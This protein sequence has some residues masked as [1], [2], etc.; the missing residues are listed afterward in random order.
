[1]LPPAES[2]PAH[3]QATAALQA[4]EARGFAGSVVVACDDDVVFQG[5]FG[6]PDRAGR[7]PSYWV[8]SISKQFAA[9]AILKLREEGRLSLDDTVERFFP[10]APRD[11]A[12]ITIS[13][14]L[15]HFSGLP[16]Q[17]YAADGVA[18]RNEAARAILSTTLA[19]EPG[20]T[21]A[22]SNDNYSLVAMIVE[23]ASGRPFEEFVGDELFAPAHLDDAGFWPTT[24]NDY[25]PP[26]LHLP[27]GAMAGAHWG[28]RGAD[29]MR[30]SVGDLHRWVR[31]LDSG[32]ALL[33]ESVRL[34]YGPN[35]RAGDGDGVGFGWF[36]SDQP[37]GRWLWTRGTEDFGGNAIVYR[38]WGTPLTIIAATNA[39]PE[40]SA[41]P[42]WSRQARDALMEIYNSA[43]CTR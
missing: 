16:R 35:A 33:P 43:A 2:Q 42:G 26:V 19:S 41:G 39:G 15:T 17:A 13:Q 36:W 12:G 10:D 28:F 31:A 5:D 18:D 8:A 29:G 32:R 27:E 6:L 21:F 4:L 37:N 7:T 3:D 25:V 20:T 1:M 9:A 34:L 40:E 14:L 22:Y 38:L 30:V 23:I 24:G 11:K